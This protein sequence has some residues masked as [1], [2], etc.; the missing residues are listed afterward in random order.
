MSRYHTPVCVLV[1]HNAKL[2]QPFD[3][4]GSFH[5]ETF[6]QLRLC[7]EVSA[8]ERIQIMLNRRIIFLIRRLDTAFR[9]HR[10]G[11]ADTKLG[12]D[13]H[14]SAC[15]DGAGGTCSAAADHKYIY[16]I[17]YLRDVNLLLHKTT[18]GV[19]HFSQLKGCFLSFVRAYFN[20]CKCI[21]IIIRMEF[22]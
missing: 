5:Y 1:K 19:K 11:V 22:L 10:V 7:S 20:L 4:V 15:V 17:I 12:H 13:H 2:V 6:Y 21:W 8:A 14:V 9:H 16:V 18:C 3:R